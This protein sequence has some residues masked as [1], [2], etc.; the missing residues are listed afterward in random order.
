MGR[1]EASASTA[2]SARWLLAKE[3]V[4]S[5]FTGLKEVLTRTPRLRNFVVWDVPRVLDLVDLLHRREF[6]RCY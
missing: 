2:A 6:S 3:G 1:W 4:D 5:F